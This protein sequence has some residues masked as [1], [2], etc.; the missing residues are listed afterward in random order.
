MIGA[1]IAGAAVARSA[2]RTGASVA[3]V[4]RRRAGEGATGRNAGFILADGADPYARVV[5][6]HGREVADAL[7]AVGLATREGVRD[8]ARRHDI[9]WVPSGS[10]RLAS[11]PDEA[12]D[13]EATADELGLT[14]LPADRLPAPWRGGPWLGGLVDEGDGAVEPLHLLDALVAEARTAGAALCEE[15]EPGQ[16]V[17]DGRRWRV[18]VGEQVLE[19]MVVVVTASHA[20][21]RL[22]PEGALPLP[23][24]AWRAQM[25]AARMRPTPRAPRPVYAR[26]GHDY[27]RV[28]PTGTV[29][30]GGQ[31]DE[32]GDG[33]RTSDEAPG[34]TVQ[35]ALERLLARW[36]PNAQ[37]R[38][39]I[40]RWAGIM[41]FTP[42]GLPLAGAWPGAENL[43]LLAGLMGHGMGWG[44]GLGEAVAAQAL[45]GAAAPAVFAP[46]RGG[47]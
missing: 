6:T 45:G 19:P 9:G 36:F 1:G 27:L 4:E 26:G 30:L 22:A 12:G 32:G 44:L 28:L 35:R 39:V 11:D 29:L 20:S 43:Y 23:L 8:L 24:T 40:A 33:E 38:K 2:A 21:G 10:L 47:V 16:P 15:A 5:T 3:W 14:W 42:D 25:L 7:R 13:L 18:V 34:A 46:A 41:A 37:R 31:R 17:R